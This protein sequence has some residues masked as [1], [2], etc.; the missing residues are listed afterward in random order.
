[1]IPSLSI[2]RWTLGVGRLKE[3]AASAQP[4]YAKGF[5]VAGA[6]LSRRSESEGGTLNSERL[7]EHG[8]QHPTRQR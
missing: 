6:H 8:A 5:G 1:M 4:A 2:G 7:R 3:P